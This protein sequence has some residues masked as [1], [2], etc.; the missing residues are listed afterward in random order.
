MEIGLIFLIKHDFHWD[1]LVVVSH[2]KTFLFVARSFFHKV[3][4]AK[5]INKTYKFAILI[6]SLSQKGFYKNSLAKEVINKTEYIIKRKNR[7]LLTK[8]MKQET[9]KKIKLWCY[10]RFTTF[11]GDAN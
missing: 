9:T 4:W 1:L 2:Q 10:G 11:L 8:T 6:L 7:F 3:F 5:S